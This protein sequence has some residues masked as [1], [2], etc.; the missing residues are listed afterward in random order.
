[1]PPDAGRIQVTIA[2][3][4][5]RI[6]ARTRGPVDPGEG[7]SAS[8]QDDGHAQ[9]TTPLRQRG[10]QCTVECGLPARTVRAELPDHSTLTIS[11]PQAPRAVRPPGPPTSWLATRTHPYDTAVH[12]VVYNSRPGGPHAQHHGDV[13]PLLAAIDTL[14]D[15]LGVLPRGPIATFARVNAADSILH[16]AG[17]VAKVTSRGRLHYLPAAVTDPVEQRRA[18]T[19]AVDALQ[20]EGIIVS[21]ERALLGSSAPVHGDRP[22]PLGDQ[23][24]DLARSIALADDTTQAV[25]WLSELTAPE[26]GVLDRLTEVLD[27]TANWWESLAGPADPLHADRLRQV[28]RMLTVS[29]L[30]IRELRDTLADRPAAHPRATTQDRIEA[31]ASRCAAP[32]APPATA[33]HTALP[34]RSRTRS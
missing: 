10:L 2:Q 15:R 12:S 25:A 23:L 34:A 31:S 24:V 8:G 27:A 20:A 32:K 3:Q 7:T 26:D 6:T 9:L 28:T 30:E 16:R 1:M 19:C 29:F 18:V 5:G 22:I 14:L 21:C 13:P 17:F 4:D 33:A 11:P